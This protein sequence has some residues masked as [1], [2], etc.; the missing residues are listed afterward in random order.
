MKKFSILKILFLDA[1]IVVMLFIWE[2]NK[3]FNLWDESYLWYGVQRVMLGEVPIRDF[4]AYDPGRYYW[5][6]A[7]MSAWNDNSIIALRISDALF[8]VIGVFVGLYLI[9]RTVKK[10]DLFYLLLSSIT[11]VIWMTM[12]FKVA[13][14][15]MSIFLIGALTFLIENPTSKRYFFTGLCVGLAAF[16]GR[17][18][19][20]YGV[21]GSLG[22]MLWLS[23]KRTEGPELIKALSL[24]SVG[25]IT[26]FMPMLFMMLLVS[27]F[28][29]AFWESIIFLFEIKTTNLVLP[30]PWPWKVNFASIS[31]DAAIHRVMVGLFFIAAVAFG[32]LSITWVVWQ[33]FQN[34]QVSPALAAAS[35]LALP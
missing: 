24:W 23:I 9:A 17:N 28:A 19:G 3:G 20:M 14:Y 10:Q 22:V 16:F 29:S 31:L 6:A 21:V 2:G 35:F 5:S 27:G 13:D 32:V 25:V 34:K 12:N 30:I 33:K 8:Q 26:G 11:L 18:H 7:F 15:T 1:F 4:M